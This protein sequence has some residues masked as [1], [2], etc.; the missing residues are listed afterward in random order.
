MLLG[1]QPQFFGLEALLPAPD[2]RRVFTAE[3]LFDCVLFC[4]P[5]SS[6]EEILGSYPDISAEMQDLA[7]QRLDLYRS[8]LGIVSDN[9]QSAI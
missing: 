8:E 9:A 2:H 4:V 1:T 5:A 7:Q 3:V 6:F